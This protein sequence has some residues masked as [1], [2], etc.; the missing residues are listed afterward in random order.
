MQWVLQIDET[1]ESIVHS[2]FDG[3]H[4]DFMRDTA[5]GILAPLIAKFK[6][7]T[8]IGGVIR[9]TAIQTAIE[10]AVQEPFN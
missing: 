10:E 9:D 6:L 5:F 1:A 3:M 2:F 4:T 7:P 8:T